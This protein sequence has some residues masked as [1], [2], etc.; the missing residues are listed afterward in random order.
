MTRR[1]VI[2]PDAARA[3]DAIFRDITPYNLPAAERY[4]P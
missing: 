4:N 1:C 3:M 2:N